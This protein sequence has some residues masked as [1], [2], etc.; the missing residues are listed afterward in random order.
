MR[1][2]QAS[3]LSCPTFTRYSNS[4][5][6]IGYPYR[7]YDRLAHDGDQDVVPAFQF[8]PIFS[9]FIDGQRYFA[10]QLFSMSV[11]TG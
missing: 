4:L 2:A 8:L 9:G 6:R 1:Y 11:S 5:L 3:R 7:F 10:C